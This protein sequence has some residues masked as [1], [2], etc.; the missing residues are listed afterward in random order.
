MPMISPGVQAS[1][2]KPAMK[3]YHT[4]QKALL[5]RQ[6]RLQGGHVPRASA[7]STAKIRATGPVRMPAVMHMARITH[8]VWYVWV[9][10]TLCRTGACF[11]ARPSEVR[12]NV[13]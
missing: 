9:T 2:G 12:R 5:H 8:R 3:G 7:R 4:W 10:R 1:S 13:Y 11:D 6:V